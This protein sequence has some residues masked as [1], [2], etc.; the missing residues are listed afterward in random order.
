MA[1][2]REECM[3]YVTLGDGDFTFSL[4]LAGWLSNATH[5]DRDKNGCTVPRR[6]L[7]CTGL[8]SLSSLTSKYQDTPFVLKQLNKY[9]DN[10][11]F[12]VTVEHEV[13]AM[14]PPAPLAS[15]LPAQIILFNHPHLA[16]ENAKLHYNFLCHLFH[17]VWHSYIA[18]NGI[19]LLTL[20][21]GQYERWD[22]EK[23]AVQQGMR[24]VWRGPFQPPQPPKNRENS[25]RTYYAL[26]RHQ[27]G[28]SFANRVLGTSET[29]VFQRLLDTPDPQWEKYVGWLFSQPSSASKEGENTEEA[30]QDREQTSD[31]HPCPF[32]DKRFSE[33]RSVRSHIRCKHSKRKRESKVSCGLCSREGLIR[34]FDSAQGLE[35]HINA[36]HRALHK[37]IRPDWYQTSDQMNAP[38]TA[39][40]KSCR[41]CN[42]RLFGSDTDQALKIHMESFLPQIDR[43]DQPSFECSFCKKVFQQN[44]A[45][46]QHENHCAKRVI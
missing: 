3:I 29:F 7:F 18:A 33:E 4:D 28:K 31:S 35:D 16:T 15:H 1:W 9:Q 21:R 43:S 39:P 41:I 32:C 38:A 42:A 19:F 22:C 20:A 10:G 8:D 13:N 44:R 25:H 26:R 46:L 40:H 5:R 2:E 12:S 37:T 36:Q 23:A 30:E 27:T 45:C 24:L 34:V 14:E 17:S 6:E 11:A